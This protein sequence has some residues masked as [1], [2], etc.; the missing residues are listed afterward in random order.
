MVFPKDYNCM[1]EDSVFFSCWSC[2]RSLRENLRA[3]EFYREINSAL[4]S[5]IVLILCNLNSLKLILRIR[6]VAPFVVYIYKMIYSPTRVLIWSIW[7]WTI[8]QRIIRERNRRICEYRIQPPLLRY[9]GPNIT[10]CNS[11]F[12]IL[13]LDIKIISN[14]IIT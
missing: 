8:S 4:N 11:L 13:L 1:F 5:I 10:R 9:F 12:I 6:I 3:W 2:R 7:F 14:V